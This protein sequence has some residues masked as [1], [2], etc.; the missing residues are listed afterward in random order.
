MEIVVW[1]PRRE[2]TSGKVTRIS[3]VIECCES[4]TIRNQMAGSRLPFIGGLSSAVELI[5]WLIYAMPYMATYTV[6]PA[7]LR[8]YNN[9]VTTTRGSLSGSSAHRIAR[10]PSTA[11]R[12]A[13][14]QG[15]A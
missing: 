7:D 15:R 13:V 5:A 4:A 6:D 12:L 3:S 8:G 11:V 10:S 1:R 9:R 14:E 2:L